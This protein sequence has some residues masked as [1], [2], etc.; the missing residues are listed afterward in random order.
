M[1]FTSVIYWD[2]GFG[3]SYEIKG[4][5]DIHSCK[6]L[7]GIWSLEFLSICFWSGTEVLDILHSFS[8]LYEFSIDAFSV[9]IYHCTGM[10]VHIHK[11]N[12]IKTAFYFLQYS[13]NAHGCTDSIQDKKEIQLQQT[14]HFPKL[15]LILE[16][17]QVKIEIQEK[18][19]WGRIYKGR[20]ERKSSDMGN[21]LLDSDTGQII[22][23]VSKR[24]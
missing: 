8:L 22:L 16:R 13:F 24:G 17:F 3:Y 15:D 11:S 20:N 19:R 21:T 7:S 5:S 18:W 1:R 14:L 12:D 6:L 4:I 10:H 2:H 23:A 9:L